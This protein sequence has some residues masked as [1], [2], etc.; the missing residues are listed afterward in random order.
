M[1][2]DPVQRMA[3]AVVLKEMDIKERFK[4]D[5]PVLYW[6]TQY[7]R[8][9]RGERMTFRGVPY[10]IALYRDILKYHFFVVMKPVQRGLSEL[11]IV[12]SF[13]EA[14]ELGYIVFYVLPKYKGRD[15]FVNSR[16]DTVL[17]RVGA[18]SRMVQEAAGTTR[19][20]LKQIGKGQI[21][22]VGSNVEDEFIEAPVDSAFV[23]EKDRCNQRNLLLLPDRLTASPYKF[24]REISTPT[25][26][27]RGIDGRIQTSTKGQWMIK[28]GH[29]GT[30]FVP[31]FFE[32]VV[33]QVEEKRWILRDEAVGEREEPRLVCARC[34]GTVDRLSE[35]EY[36]EE[37]PGREWVGRIIP[38]VV[39]PAVTL[40]SLFNEWLSSFLNAQK[41]EFFFNQRLGLA[42]TS[43][44]AKF[45][46]G[47][48]NSVETPYQYPI[49]PEKIKG[50]VF[51]GV[52]VGDSLT[53][54]IRER[55][56]D[57]Q[58]YIR[59]R[60]ILATEVP[61]FSL[62]EELL[63]KYNPKVCVVD[64]DPEIHEV[65]ALKEKFKQVYASR[66]QH[67]NL[68][69]DVNR[70]EKKVG[71]DRTA[72]I[73]YLKSQFIALSV[74]NPEGSAVL[75]GGRYY[76]QMKA[77]TRVL[78]VNENNPEKSYYSWE[79]N[80]PDHFML[81]ETYC[82]Q[83]DRVVPVDS[84]L[85]Y[86]VQAAQNMAAQ[87]QRVVATGQAGGPKTEEELRQMSQMTPEQFL[88]ML[89]KTR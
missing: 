37:F 28:C 89:R 75:V 16:I 41:R 33:R 36:V 8:N 53:I 14:A 59:R 82:A 27:G 20:A 21:M 11:F 81:A 67:G 22:Y 40:R 52:D 34:G 63:K 17:R 73:D 68:D 6:A 85:D 15:R 1:S 58:N 43:E 57:E 56:K 12:T 70:E 51:M 74:M 9:I 23:D 46:D 24:H 69:F 60:L 80:A 31:G 5:A 7:H 76:S 55:V 50:P 39:T 44:G 87:G 35:G 29:C 32:N 47:V 71:Q 18:Y 19:V 86:Y 26:E 64:A 10:L 2:E 66:F 38:A 78:L 72:A 83:A 3:E 45:T 48:L 54:T 4:R 65:A 25:I 79:E 30:H 49:E 88:A 84:A 77:S 62:V 61:S 42:Y 13:Y